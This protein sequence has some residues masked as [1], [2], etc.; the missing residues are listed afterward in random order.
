MSKSGRESPFYK[1]YILAGYS[2]NQ[3]QET[4]KAEVN[5]VGNEAGQH[6]S[7]QGHGGWVWA[8]SS[9]SEVVS[10]VGNIALENGSET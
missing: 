3:M 5:V 6:M 4:N 9:A 1:A 2:E 8:G 10:A 7:S